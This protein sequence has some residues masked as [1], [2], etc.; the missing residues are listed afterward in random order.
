[1]GVHDSF[2]HPW[3][4][5]LQQCTN[6]RGTLSVGLTSSCGMP[7]GAAMG[8]IAMTRLCYFWHF[9][10]RAYCPQVRSL[11]FEDNLG[12]VAL[13]PAL[14]AMGWTCLVDLFHL[15]N[16]QIDVGKSYCW[17]LNPTHRKQPLAMPC[18]RV[19][20]AHE[21]GGVLS[22]TKQKFTGLPYSETAASMEEIAGE[23]SPF[24][25]E[26]GSH[27]SSLFGSCFAWYQWFLPGR[28]CSSHSSSSWFE[29]GSCGR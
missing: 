11:S 19:D 7:E 17:A 26:T 18:A 10:M 5:F 4:S 16:L 22:F 9:Y 24:A 27:S 23:F 15:W 14:L 20:H 29:A 21:L 25:T 6:V 8:V 3:S 12:V 1:M 28:A 2:I 13:L